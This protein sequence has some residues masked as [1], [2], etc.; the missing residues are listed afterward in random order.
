MAS[1]TWSNT[2]PGSDMTAS[3]VDD[4]IRTDL[5]EFASGITSAMWL[6]DGSAQS[7]G[8]FKGGTLRVA[9]VT[10]N[11]GVNVRRATGAEGYLLFER[12][13][14]V[15]DGVTNRGVQYGGLYHIG[16]SDTAM[17]AHVAMQEQGTAPTT[18]NA[19]WVVA[20]GTATISATSSSEMRST[21]TYGPTYS[22]GSDVRVFVS[23]LSSSEFLTSD[24]TIIVGAQ[25]VKANTF[26]SAVSWTART[27]PVYTDDDA[28]VF[29]LAWLSEGTVT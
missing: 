1:I 2:T 23:L 21:I 20:R 11:P 24:D 26:E 19:R 5:T 29:T 9:S 7:D 25:K 4:Q 18:L 8:Q 16:S 17:V 27:T 15:Y 28:P 12:P 13:E 14:L 22:H 10:V 6:G 3:D